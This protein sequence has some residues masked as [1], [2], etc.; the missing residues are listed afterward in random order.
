MNKIILLILTTLVGSTV[1]AENFPKGLALTVTNRRPLVL[2]DDN[3]LNNFAHSQNYY[4]NVNLH[5]GMRVSFSASY[6]V[7]G[8]AAQARGTLVQQNGKFL[9]R[10]EANPGGNLLLPPGLAFNSGSG[11]SLWDIGAYMDLINRVAFDTGGDHDALYDGTA[12]ALVDF[13]GG[14]ASTSFSYTD[15]MEVRLHKNLNGAT[16]NFQAYYAKGT[17]PVA[18]T[19]EEDTVPAGNFQ[20]YL[21]Q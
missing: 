16:S 20:F 2:S 15:A 10:Q 4:L 18:L 13:T 8:E 11:I 17:G 14:T 19:F 1:W 9:F 3:T 6:G 21:G 7:G 12:A 5:E